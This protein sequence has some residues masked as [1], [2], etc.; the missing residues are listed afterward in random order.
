MQDKYV[1]E[2]TQ[3]I[4][5]YYL[6]RG[7]KYTARRINACQQYARCRHRHCPR[8]AHSLA[9]NRFKKVNGL[10]H[11]LFEQHPRMQ[12]PRFVTFTTGD[13]PIQFIG[14][15]I[16]ELNATTTTTLSSI[17]AYGWYRQAEVVPSARIG[18]SH[19]N[20]HAHTI[21]FLPQRQIVTAEQLHMSWS[22]TL[23]TNA[24]ITARNVE[25]EP[26]RHL[27]ATLR[28]Y[29]KAEQPIKMLTEPG[30]ERFDT[31]LFAAYSEQ[32]A[33][34]HLHRLATFHDL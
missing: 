20:I 12:T 1:L 27:E 8:C 11:R 6:V 31:T 16:T 29:T 33:G 18:M 19:A 5:A 25:L 10:Y 13:M 32:T 7:D 21:L 34:K 17:D 9:L 23:G 14:S 2:K 24:T 30:T 26:A 4:V 3:M 15:T 28:Y 22:Q